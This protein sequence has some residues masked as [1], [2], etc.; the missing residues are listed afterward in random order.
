MGFG[1]PGWNLGT[2]IEEVILDNEEKTTTYTKTGATGLLLGTVKLPA[3][4]NHQVVSFIYSLSGETRYVEFTGEI[5]FWI[6]DGTEKIVISAE[7]IPD[8]NYRFQTLYG[9][10]ASNFPMDRS[11]KG[12]TALELRVY[13]IGDDTHP[14]ALQYCR[15]CVLTVVPLYES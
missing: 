9:V 7:P 10:G 2:P 15:N 8:V 5:S 14:D 1:P 13:L 4:K 11:Q 12:N 3:P 6:W